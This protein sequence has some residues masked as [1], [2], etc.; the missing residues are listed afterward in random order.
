MGRIDP[1]TLLE[2][3]EGDIEALSDRATAWLDLQGLHDAEA[4]SSRVVRDYVQRGILSRPER[5]GRD[6]VYETR[7]LIELLAA[8][9]LVRDGWPLAKIA[10]FMAGAKPEDLRALLAPRPSPQSALDAVRQIKARVAMPKEALMLRMTGDQ[11]KASALRA[12][13]PAHVAQIPGGHPHVRVE[14][15]SKLEFADDL[16]VLI[17]ERRLAVMTFDDAEAIG[18]AVTAALLAAKPRGGKP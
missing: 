5:R 6:A 8:R 13:A 10:E 2:H 11:M 14:R 7:H 16:T 9:A 1:S 15:M 18:R 4:P 12:A 3:F 17:G